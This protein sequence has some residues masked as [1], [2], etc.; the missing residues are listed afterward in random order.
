LGLLLAGAPVLAVVPVPMLVKG[1]AHLSSA[2]T[3]M[4]RKM[5]A[6]DMARTMCSVLKAQCTER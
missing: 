5:V 4:V 2:P 3:K 1:P 6:L